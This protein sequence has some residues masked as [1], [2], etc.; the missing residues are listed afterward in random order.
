MVTPTSDA[1]ENEEMKMATVHAAGGNRWTSLADFSQRQNLGANMTTPIVF[2]FPGEARACAFPASP[3]PRFLSA[4]DRCADCWHWSTSLLCTVVD[5]LFRILDGVP[6][7]CV[8][9]QADPLRRTCQVLAIGARIV[10][11]CSTGYAESSP[12]SSKAAVLAWKRSSSSSVRTLP[13]PERC[14]TSNQ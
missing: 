7:S 10:V 1:S 2:L 8:A 3:N 9:S 14:M 4:L 6:V 12:I 5:N 11:Q 13:S